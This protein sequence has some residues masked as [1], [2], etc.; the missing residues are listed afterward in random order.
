MGPSTTSVRARWG[1]VVLLLG[2]TLI[3]VEAGAPNSPLVPA[4]PAGVGPPRA[5]VRAAR[6][7]GLDGL[8]RT[9]LTVVGVATLAVLVAAFAVVALEAWRGRVGVGAV[10][11]ATGLALAL[12]VL[13]PVLLSRDVYSYA[14]Y[15][16]IFALHHAN[17]YVAPPSAFPSDPFV[18]VASPE[19]IHTP[20][21]YGHASSRRGRICSSS[22]VDV[23]PAGIEPATHGLGNGVSDPVQPY[24]V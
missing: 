3:D 14:A 20:S 11:S 1:L 19:W 9:Q 6:W 12:A 23:P 13:A 16:R 18:R 22:L 2:Y 8:S 17:P 15:G 24:L 7:L 21:V 5:A 4:L 10:L